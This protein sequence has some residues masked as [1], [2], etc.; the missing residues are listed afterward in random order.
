MFDWH[1]VLGCTPCSPACLHCA[2][3]RWLNSLHKP[4]L[5]QLTRRISDGKVA[6]LLGE[7]RTVPIF[8]G[9]VKLRPSKLKEPLYLVPETQVFVCGCSD[10]FHIEVP[11]EFIGKM[12]RVIE[13]CP[14]LTFFLITRRPDRA[15]KFAEW[16][17]KSFPDNLWIGTSAETQPLF[18]M[19][20]SSLRLIPAKYRGISLK[21]LHESID[22]TTQIGAFNLVIAG[23]ASGLGSQPVHVDWLR[24]IRDDSQQLGIAFQ[25]HQWGSWGL[26]CSPACTAHIWV[27]PYGE[28]NINGVGQMMH[29]VGC[30]TS[31]RSLDG[32]E[33]DQY[34]DTIGKL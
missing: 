17:G 12:V 31:G 10:A 26:E 30:V 29:R 19:R 18:D 33:W 23:G 24:K 16:H 13:E 28:L 7:E 1:P 8:N 4:Y 2:S 6:R 34:P 3:A 9:T 14:T 20:A 22:I 27:T 25:F 11:F 5:S 21:P 32:E 15:A